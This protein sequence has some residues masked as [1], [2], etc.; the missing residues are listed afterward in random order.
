M[1][2]VGA[3]VETYRQ[4]W[5]ESDAAKAAGLFTEDATYRSNIFE[6][7]HSGHEGI[8]AYWTSV[9]ATQSDIEV[10][11]GR[12]IVDGERVSVEFW[13]TMNNEGADVTLPGCLLLEFADDG[14]CRR[15]HEYYEFMAGRLEPPE[16]WG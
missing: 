2:D 14:R 10:R 11:M 5:E 12:P 16:E 15:L 3:W 13:T 1:T 9:T 4:A 8:A 6:E 7:P